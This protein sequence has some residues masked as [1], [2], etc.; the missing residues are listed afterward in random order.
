MKTFFQQYSENRDTNSNIK[1]ESLEKF[2]TDLGLALEDI[3]TLVMAFAAGC[4]NVSE[5]YSYAEFKT[6]LKEL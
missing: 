6:M 2:I 3:L 5:G 4:K 1:D